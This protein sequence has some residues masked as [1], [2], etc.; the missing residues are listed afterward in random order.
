MPL[1]RIFEII[2]N[3]LG[4][5]ANEQTYNYSAK[6]L[7]RKLS[8]SPDM[9]VNCMNKNNHQTEVS[10]TDSSL[11][12]FDFQNEVHFLFVEHKNPKIKN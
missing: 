5:N 4:F 3:L 6:Q 8:E 2:E 12:S 9:C 1:L 7:K 10:L 11:V